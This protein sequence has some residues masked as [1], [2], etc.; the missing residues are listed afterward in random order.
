M[1]NGP[2]PEGLP[3]ANIRSLY[4]DPEN[5]LWIGSYDTGMARFKDGKFTHYD[6]KIGL[7]NDGAFQILEDAEQRFWINSNRGIYRVD[8]K[9]LNEFAAGTRTSITSVAYGK[10]DGMLNVE[11]NGGRSPGGIKAADGRLWFPTQDG[12]AVINPNDIRINSQPPPV[13]VE[14]IKIDNQ[15]VAVEALNNALGKAQTDIEIESSRQN[16]E[17]Q[18][19]AVSFINSENLRFKYRLAG[20]SDEWIDAGMRRTAYFLMFHR[21]HTFFRLLRP[22]ATAFGTLKDKV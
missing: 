21:E 5:V 10:S 2:R 7:F 15:S 8:K 16:F 11:G 9:E 13:I 6:T 22:I 12:V 1:K 14:D 18:Y 17:V 3:T 20:L 4:L 19:T